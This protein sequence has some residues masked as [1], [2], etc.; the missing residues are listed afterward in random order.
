[1][2][3]GIASFGEPVVERK[4]P[5][6]MMSNHGPLISHNLFQKSALLWRLPNFLAQFVHSW[7]GPEFHVQSITTLLSFKTSKQREKNTLSILCVSDRTILSTVFAFQSLYEVDSFFILLR[8]KLISS[9]PQLFFSYI[10]TVNIKAKPLFF[11]NL[12]TSL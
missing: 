10:F 1:M 4:E 12:H 11:Q 9:L 3:G 2:W 8:N 7:K 5:R 6:E